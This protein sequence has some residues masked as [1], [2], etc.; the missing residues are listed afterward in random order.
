[1]RMCIPGW[2]L[3][4][5]DAGRETTPPRHPKLKHRLRLMT[6][7]LWLGRRR[8]C[9]VSANDFVLFCY[10]SLFFLIS[11]FY[12]GNEIFSFRK[13]PRNLFL[14]FLDYCYCLVTP[15]WDGQTQRDRKSFKLPFPFQKNCYFFLFLWRGLSGGHRFRDVEWW[16]PSLMSMKMASVPGQ[17][18]NRKRENENEKERVRARHLCVQREIRKHRR[19][20]VS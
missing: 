14:F 12:F 7:S 3:L 9:R 17:R 5:L 10:F 6:S 13:P 11:D 20:S 18:Y 4:L 2:L 15:D 16:T 19:T 8:P 1:M